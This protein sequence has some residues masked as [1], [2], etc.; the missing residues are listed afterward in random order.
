M[1]KRISILYFFLTA[2]LFPSCNDYLKE[3]QVSTLTADYVQ[4]EKGIEDL[5]RACYEGV[6]FIFSY[7]W[8]YCLT[9]FGLDEYT[10]G[11]QTT[12]FYYNTYD[13]AN[14][15]SAP[16]GSGG[17]VE[18]WNVT[19]AMINNCNAGIDGI[20]Q[21]QFE[22]NPANADIRMGELRFLR[23]FYYFNLVQQYGGV[24]LVLKSS[25]E[26]QW[27]Y[28][29]ASV[30]EVYRTIIADLRYAANAL[31][32]TTTDYGRA[33]QGAACHY[34]AKVY[35][36]RA[37]AVT[38]E[39]GTQPTDLDS[40]IYFAE[41][42]IKSN[43]YA[44]EEDFGQI[45][46]VPVYTPSSNSYALS[47]GKNYRS[48]EVIFSAQ[49]DD[50][51]AN[52]GRYGNSS[53]L[54]WL[55]QY[56]TQ[57]GMVRDMFGRP[58]RRMTVTD[59]TLDVF[60]REND[61][62]FSKTFKMMFNCNSKA[63]ADNNTW[64]SANAPTPD[65]V[66][67]AR[68]A[69]GDTAFVLVMN[70]SLQPLSDNELDKK[71]R[72]KVWPRYKKD[73][74]GKVVSGFTRDVSPCMIKQEDPYRSSVNETMGTKDGILARLGETYLIVAEAYGRKGD[75][76]T[77]CDYI[78]VLRRR[79]A[80]KEGESKP[81]HRYFEKGLQADKSGTYDK[82]K[83]SPEYF[84]TSDYDRREMFDRVNAQTPQ[85][86]FIHFMLNERTREMTGELNRWTDLQRTETFYIR[87]KAFNKLP[88]A[89]ESDATN[90]QPYHCLR[91]IPQSWLD[92]VHKNG[93]PLTSDE[94]KAMQNPGF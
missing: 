53:H 21:V 12:W 40:C 24:P 77:A 6:R 28:T 36:T 54:Y 71:F 51:K 64:T 20:P 80:F 35:L 61:S 37:S 16:P 8:S 58:Y 44:L 92:A 75:Y 94:K 93:K 83:V 84:T 91:P 59:Y 70:D 31:P 49:F 33:V 90:L 34:L 73:I 13:P 47:T 9:S 25:S 87:T 17:I 86:R 89:K 60:D 50:A 15:N 23:A 85:S 82:I 42:V 63:S 65:L 46:G 41:Q 43:R 7:E 11:S 5:T 38:E 66:G 74:S 27:E 45:N 79:A 62:R 39:R 19:Y 10:F 55:I 30:A 4:S 18:L 3:E 81:L 67:K 78:N 2:L 32:E 29:R 1:Q 76:Q 14:Y 69:L 48:K 57:P 56:D 88:N 26:P 72:Y 22:K 68:F 52:M